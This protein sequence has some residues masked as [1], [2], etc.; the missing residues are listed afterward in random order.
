MRFIMGTPSFLDVSEIF[1][2]AS[3]AFG[4][5]LEGKSRLRARVVDTAEA[6]FTLRRIQ[7]LK[8]AAVSLRLGPPSTLIHH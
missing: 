3:S 7:K 5:R 8:N 6:S 4:A 1:L 2:V